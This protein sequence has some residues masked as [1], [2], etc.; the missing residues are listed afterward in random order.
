VVVVRLSSTFF[1]TLPNRNRNR[2]RISSLCW[3]RFASGSLI[4]GEESLSGGYGCNEHPGRRRG[5]RA[6]SGFVVVRRGSL[7]SL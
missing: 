2:N 5:K 6:S 1:L 4:S 3:R 7:G